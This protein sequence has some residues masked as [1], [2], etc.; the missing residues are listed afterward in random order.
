MC[1]PES[2]TAAILIT[3]GGPLAGSLRA[4]MDQPTISIMSNVFSNLVK[5]SLY[6]SLYSH[7]TSSERGDNWLS[8]QDI[9]DHRSP[10]RD[11]FA[12]FGLQRLI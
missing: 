3:L 2:I 12:I 1:P 7:R 9:A 4:P 10:E 6:A 8:R 11:W 5:S